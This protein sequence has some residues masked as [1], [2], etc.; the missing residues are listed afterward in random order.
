MRVLT[1]QRGPSSEQGT[2]G[3]AHASDALLSLQTLELPWHDNQHDRSCIPLGEYR[4]HWA[5]SPSKGWCYHLL[6][7]PRRSAILIHAAN[8][9]GDVDHGFESE[10]RGCIAPGTAHGPLEN[11]HGRVQQAIYNSRHALDKLHDW[12]A[13]EDFMLHILPP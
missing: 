5:E 11:V 7:V 1:L 8:F 10:L 9:G 6:N 3:H 4:C 12:G 13:G 2:F